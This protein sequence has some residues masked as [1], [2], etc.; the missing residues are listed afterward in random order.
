MLWSTPAAQ[1]L[2]RELAQSLERLRFRYSNSYR[3]Q[4][5]MERLGE[6]R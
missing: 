4:L 1:R 3:Q 5:G 2:R 6:F